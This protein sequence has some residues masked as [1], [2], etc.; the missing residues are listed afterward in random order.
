MYLRKEH[1]CSLNFHRVPS[2]DLSPF[3]GRGPQTGQLPTQ[4]CPSSAAAA[5]LSLSLP[6]SEAQRH[7]INI[8][9]AF[10]INKKHRLLFRGRHGVNLN[11]PISPCISPAVGFTQSLIEILQR[12]DAAGSRGRPAHRRI[13]EGQRRFVKS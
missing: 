13:S 2:P 5:T 4:I 10:L 11:Q 1:L 3:E 8:D 9:T 12:S 6:D 7:L